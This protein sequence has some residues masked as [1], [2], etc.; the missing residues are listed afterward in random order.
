MIAVSGAIIV[1]IA[2]ILFFAFLYY[3]PIDLWIRTIAAGVPLG[4]IALVRMRLIGI[5]PG[6]IVTNYVRAR[7][8]GLNLTR[9]SDAVAL[10]CR[11]QR[12]E[13]YAGDDR[14]ATRADSAG[15]AAR[16]RDRSCGA[17]TCSKRSRRR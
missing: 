7:K 6:V 1:F 15:V 8:A 17:R 3:F 13:R 12:R 9:R 14:R 11:R 2:L 10:P 16:R 5:P 4:I